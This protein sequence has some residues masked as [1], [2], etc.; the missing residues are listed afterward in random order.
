[1][2]FNLNHNYTKKY[3]E[4]HTNIKVLTNKYTYIYINIIYIIIF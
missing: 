4:R 2:M 3:L 1:M